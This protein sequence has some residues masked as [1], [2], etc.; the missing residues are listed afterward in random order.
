[1]KLGPQQLLGDR[2]WQLA[3]FA[4]RGWPYLVPVFLGALALGVA[5]VWWADRQASLPRTGLTPRRRQVAMAFRLL[6]YAWRFRWYFLALIT[7]M[8]TFAALFNGQIV[9]LPSL[10]ESFEKEDW[11]RLKSIG[12]LAAIV[13]PLVAVFDYGVNLLEGA[14]KVRVLSTLR[15]EAIAHMLKLSLRVFGERRAGD[16]L[17][18]LTNDVQVSQNA[19]NALYG[20]LI[21]QPFMILALL[22]VAFVLNWQLT[23]GLLFGLPLFAFPILY[24]GKKIKK[25]QKRTLGSL[26]ELTEQMH[27]MFSGIRTVKAFRM[28]AAEMR[29]MERVTGSWIGKYM[30]VVRARAL[31]SSVQEL[32]QGLAIGVVLLLGVYILSQHLFNISKKEFI[33]FLLI[34]VAFNRPVKLLTKGFN[35]L[36][37]SLAACERVFELMEI[38]PE[39]SDAPDAVDVPPIRESIRFRDVSFAYREAEPVLRGIDV[40]IRRGQV[41][42]LVG[43]SGSGKSTLL[44]LVCRFYDPTS[45]RI[46]IDGTDLRRFRRDSLL[47]RIAVVSQENFLFHDSLAENIRYG[48]PGATDAEVEAAARSANVHDVIARLPKGYATEAGERGVMLSGGERQR[49]AI[50]RAI[51]RDPAILLL[52]EA[53]SA[54]DST[55]ERLVQDALNR[56]MRQG[57]R[58]TLVVAHRLS[59]IQ[60]AD[61]ILVLD[62]GQ[63]LESGTHADLLARAGMYARMIQAQ[64]GEPTAAVTAG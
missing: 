56:M 58:T 32:L 44:D 48:R 38:P 42:A 7:C 17:S 14:L 10:L 16:L 5:A 15:N 23:V 55:N 60:G 40:E 8:W 27:Q 41:V 22:V 43:A 62:R 39:I 34:C 63:I 20:D 52:D 19:L 24:L 29:E 61:L 37:E 21:L 4:E 45:G 11:G 6:E 36:Q 31:S 59:T 47:S 9:F 35:A 28:E 26:G 13:L 53:T 30:R 2:A 51:L 49:V 54:L 1:M 57:G 33:P 64:F 12:L 3:Q 25:S 46:E 18:R 50:A